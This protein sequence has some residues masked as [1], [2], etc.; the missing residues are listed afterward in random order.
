MTHYGDDGLSYCGVETGALSLFPWKVTCG[1]CLRLPT[2][3]AERA[4]WLGLVEGSLA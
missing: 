4:Q 1:R 2:V 3:Q